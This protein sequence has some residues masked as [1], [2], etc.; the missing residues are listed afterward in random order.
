MHI[1]C[2]SGPLSLAYVEYSVT[3]MH[4]G[5]MHL[6]DMSVCNPFV[7]PSDNGTTCVNIV[8]FFFFFFFLQVG[9]KCV[10]GN[11]LV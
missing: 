7:T 8:V 1:L 4:S 11:I 9:C 10:F 2:M 5:H 6:C 3:Y